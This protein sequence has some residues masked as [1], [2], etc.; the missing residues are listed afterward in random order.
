MILHLNPDVQHVLVLGAGASVGYGLPVWRDLGDLIKKRTTDNKGGSYQYKKEIFDWLD[1]V[2]K[3]KEYQ[4]LD[5]CLREEARKQ[6]YHSNGHQIENQIFEVIRDIFGEMYRENP[7]G[8]IGRL[9]QRIL[10]GN[11]GLQQ[12]IAFINYNYDDVLDRNFLDFSYLSEKERLFNFRKRLG[13]LSASSVTALCAHGSFPLASELGRFLPHISRSSDTMKTGVEGYLDVVSCYESERH[14]IRLSPN[15]SQFK[16]YLLGLGG[17][18]RVNLRNIDFDTPASEVHVT[19]KDESIK[20]EVVKFLSK[21][22][23]IPAQEVM[24]YDTC[25][26]LVEKCFAANPLSA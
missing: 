19:I 2:G 16:L 15:V 6:E 17:G 14:H 20:S 13:T 21:R 11:N 3:G 8:W 12:E 10:E 24:I 1:K 26:E 9:N 7:Q 18:L 22:Y 5:A 4:T 25:K 23:E